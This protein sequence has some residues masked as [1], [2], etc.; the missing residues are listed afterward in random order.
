MGAAGLPFLFVGTVLVKC[1]HGFVKRGLDVF[2]PYDNC[3]AVEQSSLVDRGS[4]G[5]EF[6]P[7]PM[8]GFQI[9]SLFEVWVCLKLFERCGPRPAYDILL[10]VGHDPAHG[11]AVDFD[12]LSRWQKRLRWIV[13]ALALRWA[14]EKFS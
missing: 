11:Q 4:S 6:W 1:R 7:M 5:F 2:L 3:V 9:R 8:E 13:C 10:A 12:S 14:V